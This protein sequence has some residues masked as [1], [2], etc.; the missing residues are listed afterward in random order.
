MKIKF[1][2]L[3]W[4]KGYKIYDKPWKRISSHPTLVFESEKYFYFI[5]LST[6]NE[7]L[8]DILRGESFVAK[9]VWVGKSK[10]VYSEMNLMVL[11]ARCDKNTVE[12]LDIIPEYTTRI[13]IFENYKCSNIEEL[14]IKCLSAIY[15]NFN[16]FFVYN[17]NDD[18]YQYPDLN[19]EETKLPQEFKTAILNE[20]KKKAS[21]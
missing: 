15:N 7:K 14:K 6:I 21:N 9:N 5:N 17:G 18:D 19:V 1:Y 11:V 16:F 4:T 10:K 13:H 3:K 12:T 20:L 2:G 8:R